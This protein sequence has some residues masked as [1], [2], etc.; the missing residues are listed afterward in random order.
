M[1]LRV[2][3]RTLLPACTAVVLLASLSCDHGQRLEE[4]EKWRKQ[5]V[6][7]QQKKDNEQDQ[8]VEDL[9][10]KLACDNAEVRNFI[11]KCTSEEVCDDGKVVSA[12]RNMKNMDHIMFRVQYN[13]EQPLIVEDEDRSAQLFKLI[14]RHQVVANSTK[15][16]VVAIPSLEKKSAKG[17]ASKTTIQID[18]T[19]LKS[20]AFHFRNSLYMGEYNLPK[21]VKHLEPQVPRCDSRSV[22]LVQSFQREVPDDRL[23]S[24]EQTIQHP[25]VDVLIFLVEC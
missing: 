6:E 8:A 25:Y 18:Y 1:T 12:I 9:T 19:K 2:F 24:H 21:T 20:Q 7:D 23:L 15:L 22:G 3:A 16:L 13:P 4:L 10:S 5:F 17:K 14:K 11:R